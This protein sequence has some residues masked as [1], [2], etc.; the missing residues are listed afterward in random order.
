MSKKRVTKAEIELC[1]ERFL[2]DSEREFFHD[3]FRYKDLRLVHSELIEQMKNR[4][5]DAMRQEKISYIVSR[6][7]DWDVPKNNYVIRQ[8]CSFHPYDNI[9]FQ[10]VLNRL[11]PLIEPNLS[12]SRYSF[13]VKHKKQKKLFGKRPTE[14]WLDFK[15]DTRD[16]FLNNPDYNYLVTT[17]IAGFF[18]YI[19]IKH[20]KKHL[21]MMCNNNES[22]TIE[23]LNHMLKQYSASKYSGMPQNCEPFSYLCT[24]FLDFLDKELEANS[25]KHFRY[26]DDIRVACKTRNDAKKAIVTIIRSLRTVHLNLSTAKTD[27]I[28]RNSEKF[29]ELTKDFPALLTDIDNAISKRQKREI[30]SLA[31]EL[32]KLTKQVMKQERNFDERLFR[33]CI[34]RILK[35]HYFKNIKLNM[36]AIGGNC[37]KLLDSMPARSDTF[38]RFLVLHK[39]RKYIQ[40]GLY[41][42]LQ[43]CVYPWQEINIWYLLIQC[44][45][46]K[47]TEILNLAKQRARNAGY[48]EAARN[49]IYIFLGKHGNY[50]DKKYLAELFPS[51]ESFRAKRSLIIAIQEY[52]DRNEIYNE[53]ISANNDLILVSLVK[54]IRQLSEP[55]YV[56]K[57][58]NIGS[59]FAFS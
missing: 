13:R 27:I 51:I 59:D 30:N 10:F 33:A 37:L 34:W 49:Y 22:K 12:K 42:I 43:D 19:P 3:P 17:D 5:A 16:F 2:I 29:I 7:Y 39:D 47:N 31:P 9:A 4:L 36:D 24:A 23:L 11:V 40:D 18:E 6:H 21:L 28:P 1:F 53:I 38:L 54:Y 52:Q 14:D 8:G 57:N 48:E 20:F 44:N 26:T 15:T 58:K 45:K 55:E 46:L 56:S 50:Q 25:I 32:I 41:K 35:I